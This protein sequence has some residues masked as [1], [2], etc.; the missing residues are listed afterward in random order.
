M[1]FTKQITN[2]QYAE[3]TNKKV[4]NPLVFLPFG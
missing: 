2:Q 3:F 1:M 4:F